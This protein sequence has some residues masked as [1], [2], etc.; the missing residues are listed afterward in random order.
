[1]N[2]TSSSLAVQLWELQGQPTGGCTTQAVLVDVSPALNQTAS[3]KRTEWTRTAV[4]YNLLRT[5]DLQ[6]TETF[7]S[8]ISSA[9]FRSLQD[10][11]L[12]TL[13]TNPKFAAAGFEVDVAAMTFSAKALSWSSDSAADT[14]QVQRV[15]VFAGHTLDR[16]YSFASGKP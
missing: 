13:P 8:S 7:R 3:P 14:A 9:N 11:P 15:G 4:L 10:T 6:G 2:L 12:D 16:M 1:M 5:Y